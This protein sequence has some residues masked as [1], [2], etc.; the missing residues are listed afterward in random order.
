M[1]APVHMYHRNMAAR[2]LE[3]SLFTRNL[4]VM[5][6][7]DVDD[8]EEEGKEGV[9]LEACGWDK[10]KLQE[11]SRLRSSSIQNQPALLHT[12]TAQD[13]ASRIDGIS[14]STHI[15]EIL[16]FIWAKLVHC[17]NIFIERFLPSLS[18]GLSLKGL[19]PP[20]QR[21]ALD[22]LGTI[23]VWNQT[24]NEGKLEIEQVLGSRYTKTCRTVKISKVIF[25]ERSV[26]LGKRTKSPSWPLTC[27]DLP[28]LCSPPESRQREMDH[29]TNVSI[30]GT[31]VVDS[32][33]NSFTAGGVFKQ[34]GK[35]PTQLSAF[36]KG[37]ILIRSVYCG[38]AKYSFNRVLLE[39]QSS[40]SSQVVS[41]WKGKQILPLAQLRP[42]AHKTY[43]R[44]TK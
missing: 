15:P 37:E 22:I 38:V 13:L 12:A 24:E 14:A 39:R 42:V 20:G 2:D 1:A 27:E 34:W 18:L 41:K 28:N 9:L 21:S 16:R 23:G 3:T 32:E 19:D 33:V 17:P 11:E 4:D 31:A 25:L 44:V 8:L 40:L 36:F 29:Q 26:P 10:S 7:V 6:R 43:Y 30:Y 35:Q 5:W